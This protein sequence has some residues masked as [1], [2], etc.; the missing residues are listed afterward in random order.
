MSS[1]LHVVSAVV[2]GAGLL[3]GSAAGETCII[4]GADE[5]TSAAA[6]RPTQPILKNQEVRVWRQPTRDSQPQ[7]AVIVPPRSGSFTKD[8]RG[9]PIGYPNPARERFGKTAS[10]S[11]DPPASDPRP[12]ARPVVD[13]RPP[14]RRVAAP[15][16]AAPADLPNRALDR[17]L[18]RL[19]DKRKIRESER[20]RRARLRAERENRRIQDLRK[21][22]ARLQHQSQ[23][24]L[25]DDGEVSPRTRRDLE[26][27]ERELREAQER[28]TRA[29]RE[30]REIRARGEDYDRGRALDAKGVPVPFVPGA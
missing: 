30:Y 10:V 26:R 16:P 18:E 15:A 9:N 14:A 3:A 1:K 19:E 22:F 8:Q 6:P 28:R 29:V 25:Y 12:N 20:E 24:E 27:R 5:G 11:V 17:E 21:K 7:P 13:V 4:V 23:R 2:L